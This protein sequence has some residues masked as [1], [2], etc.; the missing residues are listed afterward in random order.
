MH[1]VN[2]QMSALKPMSNPYCLLLNMMHFTGSQLTQSQLL[3]ARVRTQTPTLTKGQ[4]NHGS[5]DV[6]MLEMCRFAFPSC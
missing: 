4:A 1:C 5:T 3:G 6:E 2:S